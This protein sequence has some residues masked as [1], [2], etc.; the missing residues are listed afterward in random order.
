MTELGRFD[1]T[2]LTELENKLW[3]LVKNHSPFHAPP[4][5]TALLGVDDECGLHAEALAGYAADVAQNR[6]QCW[7]NHPLSAHLAK[8]SACRERL[9]EL[10][11]AYAA[12]PV[13]RQRA[14]ADID[15][16]F[17]S[18]QIPPAADET[19]RVSVDA[20]RP[21]LLAANYMTLPKGWYYTIELA[22]LP[23]ETKAGLLLSLLSPDGG[24]A[25]VEVQVVMLGKVLHGTTDADGQIFFPGVS[26][27]MPND[28]LIPA[29][30]IHLTLP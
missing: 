13:I 30:S 27:D 23:G 15:I 24:V 29:I 19:S 21:L 7:H 20:R 1:S 28:P 9:D 5:I 3:E 2:A 26:L 10:L 22:C 17:F 8:C 4:G 18:G 11:A 6:A 25:N 14:K 16:T 12:V